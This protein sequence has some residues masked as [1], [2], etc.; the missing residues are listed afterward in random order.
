MQSVM[1]LQ[2]KQAH[3]NSQWIKTARARFS[4]IGFFPYDIAILIWLCWCFFLNIKLNS[5]NSVGSGSGNGSATAV[6][7]SWSTPGNILT[8]RLECHQ[9]TYQASAMLKHFTIVCCRRRLFS[10]SC[11]FSLCRWHKLKNM[12]IIYGQRT[13]ITLL[14]SLSSLSASFENRLK[15]HIIPE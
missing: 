15:M 7:H 13:L 3:T 8:H 6:H 5:S 4:C 2:L 9:C 12:H 10:C 1:R 11:F 14:I